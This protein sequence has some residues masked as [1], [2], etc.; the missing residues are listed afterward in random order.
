MIAAALALV[1]AALLAVAAV[2]QQRGTEGVTDADALGAGFIATLARRPIWLAGIGA[3]VA[4][5]VVAA[6]ALG[7][8]S[9]LVVQPLLV[10]TVLFAL[11]L[12]AWADHRRLAPPEWAWAAVLAAALVA[13]FVV[14]EPSAGRDHAPAREWIPVLVASS[15]VVGGCVVGASSMPHGRARSLALAVAA[16]LLLGLAGPLT[17]TTVDAI[18]EG[19]VGLL[20]TWELWAMIACTVLGT[21]WQQ[22]SYQAGDVQTSLPAVTVLKPVVA[23]AIGITLFE[24]SLQVGRTGDVVL[25]ISLAVMVVA[26]VA[27]GRL[28]ARSLHAPTPDTAPGTPGAG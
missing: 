1:A 24:E 25:V 18:G 5:F 15:A 26:T 3:D 4:G 13:F 11:P 14:G 21:F 20:A 7:F 19:F 16:G 17:K 23:M 2:A 9:L 6:V 12:A 8:G 22:S 27:L 28:A 10:T